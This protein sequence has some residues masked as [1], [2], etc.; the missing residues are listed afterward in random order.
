MINTIKQTKSPADGAS[1][2][3]TF[4]SLWLNWGV[5]GAT[6]AKAYSHSRSNRRKFR[7]AFCIRK[8]PY[9]KSWRVVPILSPLLF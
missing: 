1:S 9:K 4:A 2:L 6:A 5:L 7:F 8:S 3:W